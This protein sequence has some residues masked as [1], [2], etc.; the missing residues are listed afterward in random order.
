MLILGQVPAIK[1]LYCSARLGNY[2]LLLFLASNGARS[3]IKNIISVG[4]GCS[5]EKAPVMEVE[6]RAGAIRLRRMDN[7]GSG[8]IDH[9]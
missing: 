4:P 2:F 1:K 6:R 5:S 3:I 9:A 8:R 7:R